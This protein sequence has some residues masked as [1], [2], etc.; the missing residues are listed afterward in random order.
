M[1]GAAVRATWVYHFRLKPII[2][3]RAQNERERK[4]VND[5]VA[6]AL[7]QAR[8]GVNMTALNGRS[9]SS[10]Y[11][12]RYGNGNGNGNGHSNTNLNSNGFDA[13]NAE[14]KTPP[15]ANRSAASGVGASAGGRRILVD[16]L[17]VSPAPN[18]NGNGNGNGAVA[19]SPNNKTGAA[20]VTA[21]AAVATS[22]KSGHSAAAPVPLAVRRGHG[23][24]APVATDT[25]VRT[26]NVAATARA[27]GA[28]AAAAAAAPNDPGG[29]T[30]GTVIA[31]TPGTGGPPRIELI[32]LRTASTAI[33]PA[34]AA[35]IPFRD[36]SSSGGTATGLTPPLNPTHTRGGSGGTAGSVTFPVA[37][38]NGP[39]GD[40]TATAAGPAA[41]PLPPPPAAVSMGSSGNISA[42]SG[43]TRTIASLDVALPAAGV[44][45][46]GSRPD[47]R[48]TDSSAHD[49]S[50]AMLLG[51]VP[52]PTVSEQPLHQPSPDPSDPNDVPLLPPVTSMDGDER[53][54]A[55]SWCD[56][57]TARA[58]QSTLI[59]ACLVYAPA[60]C[61]A[62]SHCS[63]A[64]FRF[65]S[66]SS[67]ACGCG[68]MRF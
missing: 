26:I 23:P 56:V 32:A 62:R 63:A 20:A 45:G 9:P 58:I 19:V 42:N 41:P 25:S 8:A 36:G 60:H 50:N 39:I 7:A 38:P 2:L 65:A 34:A 5:A 17:F 31:R 49:N 37:G 13:S 46:T 54:W 27:T 67:H 51:G 14:N 61:T 68:V 47:T 24:I 29:H 30:I 18:A 59:L 1:F 21:V 35:A 10:R 66:H 28:A 15:L 48:S 40:G 52:L 44:S 3:A 22:P 12:Y 64:S 11:D 53:D 4:L 57:F 55:Q 33:A 6:V 16:T 43:S